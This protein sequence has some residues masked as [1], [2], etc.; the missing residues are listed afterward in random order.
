MS[1]NRI[2]GLELGDPYDVELRGKLERLVSELSG[3][4]L[5][6][7]VEIEGLRGEIRKL[8]RDMLSMKRSL[9]IF[10]KEREQVR[11]ILR[12]LEN[13]LQTISGTR[14]D[15]ADTEKK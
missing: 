7:R 10:K 1:S 14:S 2:P 8:N 5:D 12:S 15:S 11:N 13:R 6:D 9:S 4:I 3:R